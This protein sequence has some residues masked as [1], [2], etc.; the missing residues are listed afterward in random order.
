MKTIV[1]VFAGKFG[2]LRNL[3]RI[4]S[5]VVGSEIL[6]FFECLPCWLWHSKVL[7]PSMIGRMT[8]GKQF[9][10]KNVFEIASLLK[11]DRNAG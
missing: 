3:K 10:Q 1:H 4:A 8:D 9:R 2:Y 7:I 5:V 6:T 11:G